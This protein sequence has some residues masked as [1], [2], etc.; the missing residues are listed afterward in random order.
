MIMTSIYITFQSTTLG[1]RSYLFLSDHLPL[2]SMEQ[3]LSMDKIE[4]LQCCGRSIF[5]SYLQK[6]CIQLLLIL[7]H[8]F[9]FRL[10]T[11]SLA[12]TTPPKH[13]P[14]FDKNFPLIYKQCREK[15][16]IKKYQQYLKTWKECTIEN[17]VSFLVSQCMLIDAWLLLHK[18][19]HKSH[20]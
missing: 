4:R 7:N 9:P 5:D 8:I 12:T 14:A 6:F 18:V 10:K 13:I 19:F 17:Q 1:S 3:S 16:T 15:N 20:C 11:V 2:K